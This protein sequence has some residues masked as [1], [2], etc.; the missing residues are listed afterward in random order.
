MPPT[1]A[2]IQPNGGGVERRRLA[3]W[4]AHLRLAEHLI[5]DGLQLDVEAFL[6]GS[7]AP[8]SGLP[9]ADM[10]AYEPPKR[11][12]HWHG[13]DGEIDP[14]AYYA[15]YLA[16]PSHDARAHAFHIG[17]YLHLVTD[18]E[19]TNTV[20]RPK[21]RTPLYH[22]ALADLPTYLPEIKHDWYGLDFLYLKANPNCIFYKRFRFID[23]VPDYL[24]YL[25]AGLLTETVRKIQSYYRRPE[26]DLDRPYHYLSAAEIDA[27]VDLA[28]MTLAR[29]CRDKGWR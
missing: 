19:W 3:T 6:V 14:E 27:F 21:K 1:H 8:D 2:T 9:N 26:F 16:Q 17:Y 25:P 23:T 18:L 5:A 10:T 11:I 22:K 24:D 12:T 15:R 29:L 28:G 7:V 13:D 20:W 4:I